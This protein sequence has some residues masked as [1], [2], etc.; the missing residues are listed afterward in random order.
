M[1]KLSNKALEEFK[2][3]YLSEFGI[4]LSD[5]IANKLGVELLELFEIIYR[6]LPKNGGS[7][8]FNEG[9]IVS[10]YKK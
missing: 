3:I 2:K 7:L 4:S 6:P 10:G 1:L 8:T 9:S 5:D